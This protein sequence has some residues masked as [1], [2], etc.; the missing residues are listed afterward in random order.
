MP[1]LLNGTAASSLQASEAACQALCAAR[2]SDCGAWVTDVPGCVAPHHQTYNS[3]LCWLKQRSGGAKTVHNDCR[4]SGVMGSSGNTNTVSI[5][6]PVPRDA[7]H[8]ARNVLPGNCTLHAILPGG[9]LARRD[10]ARASCGY[11]ATKLLLNNKAAPFAA[12][13]FRKV[14][15]RMVSTRPL[16]TLPMFTS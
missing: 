9:P 6:P 15:G 5:A 14:S 7:A 2:P 4:V 16:M 3:S 1:V 13:R 11:W 10:P 8:A 12:G